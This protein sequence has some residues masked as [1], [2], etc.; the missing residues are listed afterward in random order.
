VLVNYWSPTAARSAYSQ[1]WNIN[2]Q[3]ELTHNSSLDIAYVGSKG[4]RLPVRTDINQVDPKYLTTVSTSLLNSSINSPAV[5]AAG[6]TVPYPGFTGS[7]AQ[8]LRPFPQYANMSAGGRGSDTTGNSTY[9]SLQVTALKRISNGLS[10]TLAYTWSKDLTDAANN[11]VSNQA[12]NPNIYDRSLGSTAVAYLQARIA[13]WLTPHLRIR[14][15][16]L[17]TV[18]LMR[19]TLI[20]IIR[21]RRLWPKCRMAAIFLS[22]VRNPGSFMRTI[23]IPREQ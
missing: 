8:A 6:Y 9:H 15:K 3:T 21:R 20:S 4:T 22:P 10:G 12:L 19:L 23:S 16:Q 13:S 11:F 7:L 1:N 17:L 14:G 5:V 2:F 18:A